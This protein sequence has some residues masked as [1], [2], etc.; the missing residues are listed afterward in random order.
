MKNVLIVGAGRLG[1]YTAKKLHQLGHHVMVVDKKEERINRILPYVVRAEIGDSTDESFLSSIGVDDYDLC[2][3]AIGNDFLACLETTFMLKE[4]GAKVIVSRATSFSQEKFLLRNGASS[5]V[6]PE[7]ELGDWVA[8]RFSND[9]ISNYIELT[10]GY[11]LVEVKV[12]SQWNGKRVGE[13]DVRKKHGLN[14]LGVNK[15]RM[16]MNVNSDTL[17]EEGST[18]LV[19]GKY[20]DIAKVFKL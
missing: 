13:L 11:S 10:D 17:L 9:N 3:V 18:M 5:V 8:I 16:D 7:R 14:I 6:F 20:T 19:L 1:L 12:P 2:V 4:L 15:N